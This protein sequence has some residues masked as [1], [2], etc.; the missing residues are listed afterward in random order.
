MERPF[1]A[2]A[3]DLLTIFELVESEREVLYTSIKSSDSP[4]AKPFVTGASLPTLREPP[5]GDSAIAGHGYL[6]TFRETEIVGRRIDMLD[7]RAFYRFDQLL[8][9]DSITLTPGAWHSSNALLYGRIATCTNSPSSHL[10]FGLFKRAI[11]KRFRRINTFWVGP[12]AEAAW[13]QGARLTIGLRSP[14][15]YDLREPSDNAV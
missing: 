12:Q 3:D 7:G 9:P 2:F 13:K 6:V 4:Y 10:L 14:Q 11:G 8:N 5:P 15:E 1:Y